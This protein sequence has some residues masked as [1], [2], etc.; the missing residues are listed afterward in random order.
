MLYRLLKLFI[1]IG[2][3]LYYREIRVKNNAYL[4]HDG[5]MI[6]I[7]NHPNTLIDA[8]LIGHFCSQPIHYLAKGT[9]F[10]TPFKRWILG[11]LNMIPI[12]RQVDGNTSGVSNQ[13]SFE[14]CYEVLEQ[15]KT[16]V[17]FPEGNSVMELQLR[18]LKSGTARIALEAEA[19]SKGKLNLKIVPVG[20]F[21]SQA[22]RFRR[23]IFMQVGKGM[24][25][26][27]FLPEYLENSSQASKKL[28]T[29]FR[30]LLEQVIVSSGSKEQ[31]EL[32][33]TMCEI[34][35]SEKGSKDIEEKASRMKD[36][37]EKLEDIQ[38]V[39]PYLMEEIQQLVSSIQWRIDQ[40][41]FRADI[42]EKRFQSRKYMKELGL[43]LLNGLIGFPF[44]LFG[45]LHS[46]LP[47]KIT[48]KVMPKLITNIE[49]YAPIAIL[50]GL[51]LYPLNYFL[52]LGIVDYF[53]PL[54]IGLKVLYLV[55][56]PVTGL[57]AHN[58]IRLLKSINLRWKFLFLVTNQRE[59]HKLVHDKRARL[60]EVLGLK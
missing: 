23:S 37:R 27:S 52:L 36:I 17:I 57:Y 20:L 56:M 58:Y 10:N 55:A 7:A 42:L 28:T 59:A 14:A 48:E 12:N 45:M 1:G 3:R 47:F 21:Y 33:E 2:M 31:E 60:K 18:E 34:L 6:I 39:R 35:Y 51:I 43:P 4:K 53:F 13:D 38:V 5:P 11:S 24:N 41:E 26:S 46:I 15:G 16:L 30:T 40:L 29:R 19:R 25:V 9:F 49:Y 50:L 44:F 22:H 8:W 32:M 54:S